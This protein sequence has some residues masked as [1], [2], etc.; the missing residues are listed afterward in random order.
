MQD[1]HDFLADILIP[2]DL[3]QKRVSELG[4]QISRDYQGMDPILICILRGGIMFLTDLMRNMSI[5]HAI[6]FMAV[7]PHARVVHD[8]AAAAAQLRLAAADHE[9]AAAARPAR[10]G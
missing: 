3:L 7:S 9:R 8:L 5:P 1:Y 4:E 2:E 6:E 10:A